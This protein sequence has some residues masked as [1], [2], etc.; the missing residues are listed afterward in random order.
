M[1]KKYIISGLLLVLFLSIAILTFDD[2]KAKL[3]GGTIV[4]KVYG[5][6]GL[7]RTRANNL[8]LI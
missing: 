3:V 4:V 7:Y 1:N 2:S 6:S 5:L 8:K